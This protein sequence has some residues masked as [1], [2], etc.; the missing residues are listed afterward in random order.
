MKLLNKK[1]NFIT[2]ISLIVLIT[3][4]AIS[5]DVLAQSSTITSPTSGTNWYQGDTVHIN[6]TSTVDA[7]ESIDLK[8]YRDSIGV[9]INIE[10]GMLNNK[11][12]TWVIPANLE[13]AN[14]YKIQ[15]RYVEDLP[16]PVEDVIWYW[17]SDAFTIGTVTAIPGYP[18]FLLI[19]CSLI[20]TI[21][22]AV[23]LL[24]KRRFSVKA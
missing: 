21:G 24:K 9:V 4:T 8:L 2:L 11:S 13:D 17:Y 1:A 7:S 10:L 22:L 19:G 14:D 20:F 18:T 6:W 5:M 12:Y 16:E 23:Y 3:F 15:I